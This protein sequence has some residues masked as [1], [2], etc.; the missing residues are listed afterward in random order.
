MV[1]FRKVNLSDYTTIKL[2]GTA[3]IFAECASADDIRETLEFASANNIHVQIL[4][5]GSNTVFSDEGYRGIVLKIS[6]KGI[7]HEGGLLTVNAGEQWDKAVEHA[8]ENGLAGIECLSGIPGSAGATPI[9]NVGAYGQEVKDTI[10]SVVAMDRG[11]YR[12]TEFK[13]EECGFSYRDSMFKSRYKNRYVILQVKFRLKKDG[14]PELKY[15]EL[16][17]FTGTI[18]GY[19]SLNNTEKLKAIREAVLTIRGGKSMVTNESDSNSFSCGSFFTNPVISREK[20]TIF[21]SKCIELGL[22]P[23]IFEYKGSFKVSAAWLIE[24]AG[25]SKG[26]TENGVGISEKHTLAL[27][28]RGGTTKKLLDFA[29]KIRETVFKK[30]NIELQTEPEIIKS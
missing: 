1:K 12:I 24:N 4:A 29:E 25:F 30:F 18:E 16:I 22:K 9:Q 26:Y 20:L 13:N 28:N 3:E 11:S 2:G 17:D 15:K 7:F 14:E 8:V 21:E 5:G 10:E 27:V 6:N 23:V 19:K